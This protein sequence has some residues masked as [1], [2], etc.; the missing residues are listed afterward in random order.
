MTSAYPPIEPVLSQV[1]LLLNDIRDAERALNHE[2]VARLARHAIN[3]LTVISSGSARDILQDAAF[4]ALVL[5]LERLQQYDNALDA[6]N[7]WQA[8]THMDRSLISAHMVLGRIRFRQGHFDDALKVLEEVTSRAEATGFLNGLGQASLLQADVLWSMGQTSRALLVGQQALIIARQIDDVQM[9]G[10]ALIAM[11]NAHRYTGHFYDAILDAR[12]AVHAF[13]RINDRYR[14]A[15]AYH[16]LGRNYQ[17]LYDDRT[18]LDYFEKAAGIFGSD[19]VHTTLQ[20]NL[21]AALVGCDRQQEGLRHLEAALASA[22]TQGEYPALLQALYI[23]ATIRLQLGQI[24]QARVLA[25]E[26]LSLAAQK[27]V[28]RHTIRALLIL[29]RCA[30]AITNNESAHEFLHLAFVAAQQAADRSIIWQT[31]A[32]LAQQ[33]KAAHPDMARV[34]HQIALE[35]VQ[36][37]AS[38]IAENELRDVFEHAAPIRALLTVTA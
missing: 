19:S 23:A 27:N 4:Q 20:C 6:I 2:Q 12:Q 28:L 34:H 38:S 18:A 1:R 11:A 15:E 33:M 35:M 22:R 26:L 3:E 25:E 30:Q 16:T 32:A 8:R 10:E 13:E 36:S 9:Q 5:A 21:G 37:L 29:G 24:S 14:L 31:H 17:Q 7:L